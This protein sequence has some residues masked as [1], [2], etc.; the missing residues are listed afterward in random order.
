MVELEFDDEVK[1][2]LDAVGTPEDVALDWVG[3]EK[4]DKV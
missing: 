4:R 3:A 1:E 2:A